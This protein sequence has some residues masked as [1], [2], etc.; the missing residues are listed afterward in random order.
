MSVSLRYVHNDPLSI[1]E[2]FIGYIDCYEA[3]EEEDMD[4]EETRLTGKA[5]AH[6]D[7]KVCSANNID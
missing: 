4:G 3:I 2:D 5:L 7:L 1:R 6:I